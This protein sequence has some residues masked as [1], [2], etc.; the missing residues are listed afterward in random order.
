M[1]LLLDTHAALWWVADDPRYGPDAAA[2]LDSPEHEVLV[3]A[4]V[5][6]EV[7][8]KAALGKLDA[9]G[10]LGRVLRDAGARELPVRIRHAEA[11]RQLPMHHRDPF[12]RMLIAQ[13]VVE[14][15]TV[16]S[17]DTAFDAYGVPRIWD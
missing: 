15:A 12:D 10:D 13:A 4:V 6:W 14:R 11:L 17:A 16:I 8:T 9:P 2:H 7:A 3:S 1:R 5:V